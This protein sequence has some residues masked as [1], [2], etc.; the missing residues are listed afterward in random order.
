MKR[1]HEA[2]CRIHACFL[3]GSGYLVLE[4]EQTLTGKVREQLRLFYHMQSSRIRTANTRRFVVYQPA[5]VSSMVEPQGLR[6]GL[7]L[8]HVF[9]IAS[10]AMI[11]SGLF[12]LPGMAHAMAGPGVIWSYLLA[13]ILAT[14]GALSIAELA[15]AMPKP[16]G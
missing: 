1:A 12:I 11:S 7:T 9:C 8:I 13:G 2:C 4:Q 10:G 16:G 3:S 14:A 6:K 15:T 5:G